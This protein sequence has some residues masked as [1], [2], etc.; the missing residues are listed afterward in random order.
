M[1]LTDATH[2]M[3][4][5]VVGDSFSIDT[6]D[7]KSLELAAVEVKSSQ[8]GA[9]REP[10]VLTFHGPVDALLP[11]SI[12]VLEHKKLGQLEIFLVP[13]EQDESRVSYEAVFN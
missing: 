7:V 13:V 8:D 2:E 6:D 5:E 12:Y 11:Q 4:N 1:N 9:P 10:F 3:F